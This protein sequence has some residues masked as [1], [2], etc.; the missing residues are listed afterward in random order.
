MKIRTIVAASALAATGVIG[1][2]SQSASAACGV[3][4][5]ATNTGNTSAT[6]DW[7]DSDV[8]IRTWIPAPFGLGYWQEGFWAAVGTGSTVVPAGATRSHAETL[9]FNCSAQRQYRFEVTEGGST[10]WVYEPS[11][12]T[13]TTN[14]NPQFNV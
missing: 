9:T 1:A 8:R 2:A 3:T 13:W 6:V 10:R 7:A 12:T 11:S 14:I 4:L 5:E